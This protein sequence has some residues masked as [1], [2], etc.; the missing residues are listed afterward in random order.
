MSLRG[1]ATLYGMLIGRLRARHSAS[2]RRSVDGDAR[3]PRA[4]WREQRRAMPR[5]HDAYAP[6]C[7]AHVPA[8]RA[9]PAMRSQPRYA[10]AQRA[11]RLSAA[12]DAA[13]RAP[14][15]PAPAPLR[16]AA[17]CR[18]VAVVYTP[19]L[20]YA[21]AATTVVVAACRRA[22]RHNSLQ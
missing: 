21:H 3:A 5:R 17:R 18:Y 6:L 10:I 20:R 22:Y 1:Y 16:Q 14:P 8:S 12:A 4:R 15:L 13:Q 19:P 9:M 2:Q 11:V 7:A